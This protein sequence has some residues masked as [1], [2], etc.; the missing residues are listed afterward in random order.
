MRESTCFLKESTISDVISTITSDDESSS[1]LED[2]STELLAQLYLDKSSDENDHFSSNDS[3]HHSSSLSHDTSIFDHS[4]GE[5]SQT[6]SRHYHESKLITRKGSSGVKRVFVSHCVS[7][8]FGLARKTPFSVLTKNKN[9]FSSMLHEN[10][11]DGFFRERC[12]SCDFLKIGKKGSLPSGLC[13]CVCSACPTSTMSKYGKHKIGTPVR[14]TKASPETDYHIDKLKRKISSNEYTTIRNKHPCNQDSSKLSPNHCDSPSAD[15]Y[16]I[17]ECLISE[18]V[19][20]NL[21]HNKHDSL[22][23]KA[24][25]NQEVNKMKEDNNEIMNEVKNLQ[26]LDEKLSAWACWLLEKEEQKRKQKKELKKKQAKEIQKRNQLMAQKMD[27]KKMAEQK[28]KEW[29][30]AKQKELSQMKKLKEIEKKEKEIVRLQELLERTEKARLKYEEWCKKKHEEEDRKRGFEK[31]V[32][33]NKQLAKESRKEASAVAYTQWL[34]TV[35]SKKLPP[36]YS[37]GYSDGKLIEIHIISLHS[38]LKINIF[39]PWYH[40][41][42]R[43]Y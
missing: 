38:S 30:Q 31:Q 7:P 34:K 17:T 14:Y 27:R 21:L 36:Y 9:N 25:I 26:D 32:E 5:K 11:V 24:S 41:M 4:L 18:S 33:L 35:G 40:T 15:L 43:S 8:R 13:E 19:R 37:H 29:I 39:M 10:C 28:C 6:A 23:K 2:D 20:D 1:S 12:K 3:E 22:L 42:P 16:D